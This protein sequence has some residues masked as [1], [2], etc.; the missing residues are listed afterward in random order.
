MN[1]DLAFKFII[2][3]AGGWNNLLLIT[4]CMIIPV[5]GPIVLLGYQSSVGRRLLRDPQM[6][7]HPEFTFDRFGDYLNW[8]IWPFVVQLILQLV[9]MLF[10]LVFGG[11]AIGFG[12]LIKVPEVGFGLA[13]LAY[14][15]IILLGISVMWPAVIHAEL[16]RKLEFAECKAFV[17]DF[18]QRLGKSTAI[19]IIIYQ[20]I[21]FG[22]CLLGLLACF[23]GVYPAA[24]LVVMAGLHLRMQHYQMYLDAG[25]EPILRTE[26]PRE[27]EAEPID[28]A[29]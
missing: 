21:G 5:V 4:L 22:I 9:I 24:A 7:E 6:E 27:P 18:W 10:V 26:P 2:H 23:V 29:P 3:R 8:G 11:L 28:L 12:F 1:Y 13:G 20:L 17:L 14:L 19:S 16:T 25:G 15:I